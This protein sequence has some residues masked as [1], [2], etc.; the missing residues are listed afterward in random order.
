MHFRQ[1]KRKRSGINLDITPVVDTVFN[2]LIFFALSLNFIATPG[3]NVNLPQ[4]VTQEIIREKEELVVVVHKDNTIVVGGK[5]VAPEELFRLLSG[6]A[7]ENKERP[8]IIQADRES[9]HGRVVGVM[10][11]AKRAGL[12]RLVIATAQ[13]LTTDRQADGEGW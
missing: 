2:L 7:R 3:M 5:E 12:S 6:A 9:M 13:S 10:D 8:V 11:M 4:S 1:G